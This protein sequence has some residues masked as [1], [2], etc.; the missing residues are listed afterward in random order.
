M[1]VDIQYVQ[2]ATS[3]T[4]STFITKKLN[5]ISK[6]YDWIIKANVFFRIENDPTGNGKICEIQISAPGPRLFA[7]SNENHFEKAAVASL[8][9][10]EKQLRK[11]KGIL[12]KH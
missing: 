7:R 9:D 8:K 10:I 12:Q 11:R 3:E 6:K 4:M 1:T 2:M 5:A